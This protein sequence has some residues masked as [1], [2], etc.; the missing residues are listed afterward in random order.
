MNVENPHLILL[1][2]DKFSIQYIETTKKEINF[3]VLDSSTDS[4]I[5]LLC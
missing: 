1:N 3:L 5:S 4:E 2:F